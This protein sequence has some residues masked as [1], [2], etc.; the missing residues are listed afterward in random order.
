MFQINIGQYNIL[1]EQQSM[2]DKGLRKENGHIS[3]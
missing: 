2:Y 3:N 1:F